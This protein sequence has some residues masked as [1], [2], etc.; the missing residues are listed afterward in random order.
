MK[1]NNSDREVYDKAI[2]SIISCT[3]L[4][5][6]KSMV[7]VIE[8]I[9]R[10]HEH[11]VTDLNCKLQEKLQELSGH[12]IEPLNFNITFENTLTDEES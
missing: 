10:T 2:K 12:P 9:G 3:T 7:K 8:N 11:L 4:L 5:Q 6:L 1:T